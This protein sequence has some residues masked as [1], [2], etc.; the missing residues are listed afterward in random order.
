MTLSI[1][2]MMGSFTSVPRGYASLLPSA[3][4][5]ITQDSWPV[6][7][8]ELIVVEPPIQIPAAEHF[9]EV[10]RKCQTWARRSEISPASLARLRRLCEEYLPP[11]G[12]CRAH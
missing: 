12:R 11:H 1:S 2:V 9:R 4:V 5:D 6:H 7:L 8:F 3:S 10:G